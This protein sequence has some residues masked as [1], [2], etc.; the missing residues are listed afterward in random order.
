VTEPV[1]E[2]DHVSLQFRIFTEGKIG[3]LKEWIIRR[4]TG[5]RARHSVVRALQDVSFSVGRGRALGII[6]SN[7]AGKSS[8]LRIAAG[9]LRPTA[10]TAVVRGRIAPV[11]ELGI[12][13]EQELTGRENIIF[14]GALLGR[15][16]AEMLARMDE[17]V[18]FAE[19]GDFIDQPI[20]TYSTG[21]IARLA[22]SVATTVEAQVL[23]LDEVLSVG[24]EKFRLKSGNRIKSFRESGVTILFVSHTLE[25][26][27]ALC[28]EVIWMEQGRIHRCGR[29]AEVIEE[30]R[31]SVGAGRG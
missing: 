5:R 6:G 12:G 21:M 24:D 29:A 28:D 20:R 11:I 30:Y 7:G 9:I 26:V 25:S 14:N 16:Q 8:L 1:I 17:I 27:S 31:L 3:S 10:G 13:F 2:F 23:L 22:F 19:L 4:M 15:S 18:D